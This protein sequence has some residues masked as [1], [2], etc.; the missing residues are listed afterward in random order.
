MCLS[1]EHDLRGNSR[2]RE[3]ERIHCLPY[4]I[5]IHHIYNSRTHNKISCILCWVIW[6]GEIWIFVAKYARLVYM[7]G[8]LRSCA[9]TYN[10]KYTCKQQPY[11]A[12]GKHVVGCMENTSKKRHTHFARTV[13]LY[14]RVQC[15]GR[16]KGPEGQKEHS[17]L[18]LY[19]TQRM[20]STWYVYYAMICD[21]AMQ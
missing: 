8:R 1:I 15:K 5:N 14:P 16:L 2:E 7:N 9:L 10:T 13:L 11:Y 12:E 17:A 6:N 20:Y 3:R 4:L 18:Y 21:N 19:I